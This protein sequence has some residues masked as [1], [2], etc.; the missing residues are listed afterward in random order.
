M[1]LVLQWVDPSSGEANSVS[2]TTASTVPSGA[3][4]VRPRPGA[5]SPTPSTPSASK[6]L[7]QERIESFVVSHRRAT[8][9][10]AS[11]SAASSTAEACTT[12]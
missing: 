8:S 10:L 1:S 3:H 2:C 4:D 7:R 5:I 6:H 12:F 9:L 11:P